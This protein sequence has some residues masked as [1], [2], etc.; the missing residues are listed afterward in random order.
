MI[1][2]PISRRREVKKKKKDSRNIIAPKELK[3]E[4]EVPQKMEKE[5][6]RERERRLEKS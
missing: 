4:K 6:E 1:L 2:C 5:R 3:E